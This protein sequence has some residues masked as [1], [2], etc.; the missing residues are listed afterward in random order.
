MD[1]V[2]LHHA[3]V[4]CAVCIAVDGSRVESGFDMRDSTQN[5]WVHLICRCLLYTSTDTLALEFWK[6]CSFGKK[7]PVRRF[8]VFQALLEYLAMAVF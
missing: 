6:V 5:P 3:D 2:G 4:D 1:R 7:V 8:Q